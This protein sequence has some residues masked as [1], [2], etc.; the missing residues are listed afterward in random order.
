MNKKNIIRLAIY[1]FGGMLL[2][3]TF[4][5]A[6]QEQTKNEKI[7]Q[8]QVTKFTCPMH[9][10]VIQDKPGKCPVCGMELVVMKDE[11]MKMMHMHSDTVEMKPGH[12]MH[13]STRM[14]HHQMKNDSTMNM[15][16]QKHDPSGKMHHKMTKD[17]TMM[18][19]EHNMM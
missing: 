1:F 17:S 3:T 6:Q 11:Q 4:T 13:D 10:D 16:H 2:T 12:A 18:K 14:Y 5:F 19:Q 9:P 8:T 7:Q 15:Y